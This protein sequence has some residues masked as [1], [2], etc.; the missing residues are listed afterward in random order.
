MAITQENVNEAKSGYAPVNALQMY[1]EMEG[2]GKP[3]IYIPPAFGVAG[4]NRFPSLIKNH[5]VITPELHGHGRTANIVDRPIRFEQPANDVVALMKRLDIQRADF[6]GESFGGL[7]A[8]MIAIQH[9]ELVRR[10]ATY[11]SI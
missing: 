1:Y 8:T 4:V 11:G 2:S 10:V 3:L 5:R 9:P 6:L 7:I